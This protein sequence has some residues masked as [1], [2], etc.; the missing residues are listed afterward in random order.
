MGTWRRAARAWWRLSTRGKVGTVAAI[1]VV[2]AVIGTG[3][4]TATPTTGTPAAGTTAAVPSETDDGHAPNAEVDSPGASPEATPRRSATPSPSRSASPRPSSLPAAS[5]SPT[6]APRPASPRGDDALVL[7]TGRVVGVVDGDTIDLD[8]GTRVRLAIVDTPEV[9]GGTEP[10]GPEASTFT[11]DFALSQEVAILRPST[12]PVTD[13]YGRLLGE[14]VR[15]GDGASL[16]VALATAGLGQVDERYTAEDRDLAERVRAA[17][18]RAGTPS[19]GSAVAADP[20]PS[21]TLEP[22]PPPA[23]AAAAHTGRTDGGWACHDAYRECLPAGS[24][25]LDCAD[26]GHQ[27]VVL[28]DADPWRLDGNSTTRSDGTGCESYPPWSS[29]QRYPYE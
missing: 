7:R 15:T 16:N 23:G 26:V 17:A 10:C 25:D 5:P 29:S 28:G 21:P 11:R 8:D 4:D 14:V 3:D 12:A 2:A 24:G 20:A 19:C 18:A 27:V 22:A 13:P 9:H 1:V 6:A